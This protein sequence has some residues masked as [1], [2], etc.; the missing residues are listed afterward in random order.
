[1]LFFYD[2]LGCRQKKSNYHTDTTT[3]LDNDCNSEK[4]RYKNNKI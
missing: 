1:M 3:V 4:Y 2:L